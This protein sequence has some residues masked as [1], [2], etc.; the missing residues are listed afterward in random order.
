M[1]NN[2]PTILVF[3]A[4]TLLISACAPR[5]TPTPLV[6]PDIQSTLA[7]Q[8]M[9]TQSALDALEP[10]MVVPT[11]TPLP[12]LE[13]LPVPTLLTTP[14]PCNKA[15]F[16]QDVSIPDGTGFKPGEAL[17]KTWRLRNDGTCTWSG[18]SLVFFEGANMG[19][20]VTAINASVRPG[21]AVDISIDLTAPNKTG[22]YTGNYRLRDS[23][24]VTFGITSRS[25]QEISFWLKIRVELT[26][27]TYDLSSDAA[28]AHWEDGLG[29]LTYNAYGG[30]AERGSVFDSTAP[31]MEDK[32]YDNVRA[33]QVTPN[34]TKNGFV[35]GTF[36]FYT[37]QQ[38]DH[39]IA[40]VGCHA[41]A[42][43]CLVTFQLSY[44][45]EGGAPVLL[46]T[47]SEKNEGLINN[48]DVDLS[49]LAG[50]R[51][52]FSLGI[53]AGDDPVDDLGF[54]LHPRIM[55]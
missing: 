48:V 34:Y 13:T 43:K 47:W 37:I 19:A 3:I 25:G 9:Q 23:S 7:A 20:D 29:G 21:E 8:Q 26:Q 30:S 2:R 52:A 4:L 1:F 5:Q 12:P 18:Y 39:F 40:G 49:S 50:K 27:V 32:T 55:R 53:N 45:E 42:K 24:G 11:N 17:R 15:V 16:V 36:G 46:R 38:G 28:N 14:I 22:N 6:L 41:D 33:I 44:R 31:K 54:W 10:V 35:Q 51:V